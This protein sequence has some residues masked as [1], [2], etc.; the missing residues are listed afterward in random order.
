MWT[1]ER[2]KSV[3]AREAPAELGMVTLGGDPAGVILG[4][5]RRWLPV[6]SPGGYS[7]RPSA[8]EKV[9]VLKAGMEGETTCVAGVSQ[10]DSELRAGEVRISGG[11]CDILL[12]Q[13][14]LELTGALKINGQ[15]LE[16]IIRA[17]VL[18]MLK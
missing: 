14:A 4:G 2:G 6:Y 1:S 17:V 13:D 16:D 3:P 12:G 5:E 10:K 11:A 8:G 18:E 15:S 7:W 9:L